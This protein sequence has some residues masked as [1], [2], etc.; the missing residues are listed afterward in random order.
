MRGAYAVLGWGSLIWDL[1][2]LAPHVDL[3]WR[4]RAG[5][6]LPMEFTRISP[7]RKLGLV[8][9]LDAEHGTQCPTHAVV[10]RRDRLGDVIDD[11]AVR[12]RAPVEMIGGVCVGTGQVQGRAEIV[13]EVHAWCVAEG[14]AGAVWTDLRSNY[15]E[16][17][18]HA[19]TIADAIAYLKTLSGE[20]LD[21]A[22]RYLHLAPAETRTPLRRVL[23]EDPWWQDQVAAR[24]PA[25]G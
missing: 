4:M 17:A 7:K 13:A 20:N 1:D 11:L 3:P 6:P 15:A 10:S 21:E 19:F 9:C 25:Q 14:V 8:V 18:G 24:F 12:E 23:A 2:T 5:P 22:V 16:M